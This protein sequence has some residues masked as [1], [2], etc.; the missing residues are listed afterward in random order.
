MHSSLLQDL[1]IFEV[2]YRQAAPARYRGILFSLERKLTQTATLVR[3]AKI[4]SDI[5]DIGGDRVKSDIRQIYLAKC[6]TETRVS[7]RAQTC[8]SP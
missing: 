8:G 4:T 3:L 7:S 1:C 6:T 2:K 5:E